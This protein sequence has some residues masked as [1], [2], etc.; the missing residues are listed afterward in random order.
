VTLVPVGPSLVPQHVAPANVAGPVTL[1]D[2]LALWQDA[3][4]FA[5]AIAPTDFVP[6]ALRNN[7]P[8]VM[9]CIIKGHELGVSALHALSQI[10][11]IDGRPCIAAELQ[12]ALILAKGHEL[13]TEDF[14]QTMV[15]LCGR[16]HDG[17]HVQ[18]VTWTMD[19]AKRAGL[20][21]KPNWRQW[22][23][24]ML[25]AR[26]SGELGR[27]MFADVLAGLGVSLEELTDGVIDTATIQPDEPAAKPTTTRRTTSRAA[28]SAPARTDKA[29]SGSSDSPAR[30]PGGPPPPL[31][32]EEI[33]GAGPEPTATPDPAPEPAEPAEPAEVVTKRA[34]AIAMRAA[35]V[36]V[37]HHFVISAV[38][39]GLKTSAK[40]VTAAEA[41][42]VLHA[43][44]D[45]EAGRLLLVPGHPEQDVIGWTLTEADPDEP[46][47]AGSRNE[48]YQSR[49]RKLQEQRRELDRGGQQTLDGQDDET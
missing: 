17:D 6:K 12:R 31:P 5:K 37:D 43:L 2:E 13:W 46:E 38:T 48:E 14:T 24:P 32:D 25:L 16:R 34:Q 47:P 27:L 44:V 42:A 11:I 36:P 29:A 10:H 21:G 20:A 33:S 45:L 22:P 7:P 8:A 3:F 39:H 23:R 15:T 9:A 49:I 19:D 26:C 28:K 1:R 4:E 35:K 30:E 41:D 40:D 18:K